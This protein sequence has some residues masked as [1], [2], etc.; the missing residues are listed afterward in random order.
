MDTIGAVCH[1]RVPWLDRHQP[2]EPSAKHKNGPYPQRPADREENHADPAHG[3][4]VESPDLFPIRQSR[5]IC[6]EQSDQPEGN[7][8]PTVGAILTP[9]WAQIAVGRQCR[10]GEHEQ[11]DRE[12]GQRRLGE[13]G[14]GSAPAEDRQ[15]VREARRLQRELERIGEGV[16]R[17][18]QSEAPEFY[19][20]RWKD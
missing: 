19:Q 13:K 15:T 12:R 4:T 9:A 7:N 8:D 14:S 6:L 10:P 3:V 18:L 20:R 17:G 1:Q 5:Q 16:A 11:H 2:A